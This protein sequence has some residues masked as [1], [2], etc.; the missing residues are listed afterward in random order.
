MSG[1][2]LDDG[3]EG[4]GRLCCWTCGVALGVVA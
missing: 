2:H 4:G 3:H 1:G